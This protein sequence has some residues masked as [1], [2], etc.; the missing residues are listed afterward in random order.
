MDFFKAISLKDGIKLLSA[1]MPEIKRETLPL[2]DAFGRIVSKDVLSQEVVPSF[3]RSTVDGYAVKSANI[4]GASESIPALLTMVGSVEMGEAT[5]LKVK[6]GEAVY[7]P[8]GGML[9]EGADTVV[10][11]EYVEGFHDTLAIHKAQSSGD[12]VIAKGADIG[13]NDIL[14][15]KGDVLNTRFCS[16]LASCG[17]SEVEVYAP[18]KFA[19]I[20]TGDELISIDEPYRPSA[21]RDTNTTLLKGAI[22]PYGK[23][24][25]ERRIVDNKAIFRD[26]LR[27]ACQVAD[28]VL[29]S[30]GSSVGQKDATFVTLQEAGE[31]LF[32]GLA[33]KPGKP[34]ILAKT[35][36][37]IAIGLPGHPMACYMTFS[38][39]F[40]G[41]YLNHTGHASHKVIHAKAKSNFPSSPGKLSFIPVSVSYEKDGVY[42]TPLFT[43]SGMMSVIA[44]ADGFTCLDENTEG[45]NQGEG[46][47]VCLFIE[48]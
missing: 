45:I 29:L 48:D 43:K 7:V 24:V 18:L 11:I 38:N 13:T 6:D 21:V 33:V 26:T 27:K 32:H 44:K 47:E 34:T 31:V 2:H 14:M 30:G 22:R 37:K 46:I 19:I 28:V 15:R 42:A 16:L 39:L 8:T 36:S 35:Y 17:V 40:G 25:F 41:A 3:T 20:S 9:P 12:N 23:V 4:L 5:T 10:M 1:N